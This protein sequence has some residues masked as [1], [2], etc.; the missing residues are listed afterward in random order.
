[1]GGEHYESGT[2]VIF[3]LALA[4]PETT[5]T[6][7]CAAT[8]FS[9]TQAGRA[10]DNLRKRGLFDPSRISVSAEAR[11]KTERGETIFNKKGK[12]FWAPEVSPAAPVEAAVF[13]TLPPHGPRVDPNEYVADIARLAALPHEENAAELDAAARRWGRPHAEI[14][15]LVKG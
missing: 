1:S 4:V 13:T 5:R 8:G 3:K 12:V 7:L 2:R 6:A 14:F 9:R 15:G 10:I 11:A